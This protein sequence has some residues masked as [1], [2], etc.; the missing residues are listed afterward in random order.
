LTQVIH[1]TD[2]QVSCRLPRCEKLFKVIE[3]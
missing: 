1:V 3:K 2:L